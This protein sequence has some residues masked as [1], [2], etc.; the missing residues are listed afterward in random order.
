[1]LFWLALG[2]AGLPAYVSE[3]RNLYLY[4][5]NLM[6][7]EESVR[8]AVAQ[9]RGGSGK[10]YEG[11]VVTGF[12]LRM[13]REQAVKLKLDIRGEQPPAAL[14]YQ[15]IAAAEAGERF[16][17]DGVACRIDGAEHTN[18]Y[19]LTISAKK[20]GGV[21]TE[22]RIHRVLEPEADF[23]D[24]IDTLTVT[25]FLLRDQYE[26]RRCGM[27]RLTLTQVT[28][29]SDET[30]IDCADGIIGPL[31][32]YVAGKVYAEVFTATGEAMA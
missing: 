31:R 23:P 1:L 14:P 27:F 29:A 20:E 25:A 22:A 18:I 4:K 2:D 3:T 19:G 6:P 8:F 17:G 7:A 5:L 16:M 9:E 24:V 13:L 10:L 28:L 26:E 30:M 12:E 32:Y 21:K 11:C 15:D